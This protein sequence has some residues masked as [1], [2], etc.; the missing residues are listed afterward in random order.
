MLM[1]Q[2]ESKCLIFDFDNCLFDTRSMGT[3]LVVPV[4]R[5]MQE[6]DS[7]EFLTPKVNQAIE[8]DIW[9]L[10]LEDLFKKY[11]VPEQI[12]KAMRNSYTE[13]EATSLSQ[14]YS[15]FAL[16]EQFPHHKILVTSGFK[17]L[18]WSKI[19]IT[20]IERFFE[21]IIIDMIDDPENRKG[22]KAIFSELQE[23]YG[24]IPREVMVIGDSLTSE[25]KAGKEL[26]MTTVQTLRPGVI[27]VEGFDFYVSNLDELLMLM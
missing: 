22:K 3:E 6:A 9:L 18:Q 12:R 16:L 21:E 5:A 19:R 4:L 20:G 10:S 2:R 24:L 23:K 26:G 15:D 17:K 7:G 8:T 14:C 25:L 11:G 27:K 1:S 13:L